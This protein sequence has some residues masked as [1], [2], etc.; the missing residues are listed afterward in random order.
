[1]W[2]LRSCGTKVLNSDPIIISLDR[3]VLRWRPTR[4]VQRGSRQVKDRGV[5]ARPP[6]LPVVQ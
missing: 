5:S 3:V 2:G 4:A 1:M 6:V